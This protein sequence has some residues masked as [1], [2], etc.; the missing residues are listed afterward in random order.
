M[1]ADVLT[2]LHACDCT[3]PTQRLPERIVENAVKGMLPKGRL[4]RDIRLHLKVC[5]QSVLSHL[6]ANQHSTA[7]HPN[8][9]LQQRTTCCATAYRSTRALPIHMKPSSQLTSPR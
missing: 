6:Y 2:R 1:P 5:Q 7:M 9:E 8:V 3:L 4:G